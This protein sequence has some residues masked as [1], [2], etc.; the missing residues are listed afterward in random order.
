MY[1]EREAASLCEA[2]FQIDAFP[3][4]VILIAD[5]KDLSWSANIPILDFCRS[6]FMAIVSLSE[7]DPRAR[8]ISPGLE[9]WNI[10]TLQNDGTVAIQRQGVSSCARV[11]R[12]DLL[13]SVACMGVR[14]YRSLVV[15]YP[16]VDVA[17]TFEHGIRYARWKNMPVKALF[18][19]YELAQQRARRWRASLSSIENHPATLM[20]LGRLFELAH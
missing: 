9:P 7:T 20:S 15:A 3:C 2:D 16:V 11:A 12:E 13:R 19:V 14:A 10:L 6:L 4:E 18:T 17:A 1:T 5:D 8:F